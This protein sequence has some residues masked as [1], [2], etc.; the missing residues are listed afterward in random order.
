L[1]TGKRYKFILKNQIFN[2]DLLIA[3]C[4]I[5]T[6]TIFKPSV[7]IGLDKL[8]E[9]KN[10]I[11]PGNYF[12]CM[13]PADWSMLDQTFGM[14]QEKRKVYGFSIFERSSG[15]ADRPAMISVYYFAPGNILHR[16]MDKYIKLHAEPVLGF[17]EEGASYGEVRQIEFMERKVNIFERTIIHLLVPRS[18]DSPKISVFEKFVVV[19][20][21]KDEGFY[22]LKLSVP[23][24]RKEKYTE[25][26]EATVKSFQP[27]K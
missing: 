24:E 4:I 2:R 10:Y 8:P 23:S 16:T 15:Q 5:I 25:I 6:L 7:C 19:P 22:V 3:A 9:Y 27:E 26:F 18:I 1:L 20:T 12:K 11:S 21:K 14:P 13:I 17:V